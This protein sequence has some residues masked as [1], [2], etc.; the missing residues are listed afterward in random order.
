MDVVKQ[1]KFFVSFQKNKG[2]VKWREI[3]VGRGG[4]KNL[5]DLSK[6]AFGYLYIM[7]YGDKA[8]ISRFTLY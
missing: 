3:T 5:L 8:E 4:K 7:I 1:Q 6:S 2:G